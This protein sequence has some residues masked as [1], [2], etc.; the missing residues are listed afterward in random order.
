M[1]GFRYGLCSN[2]KARTE[3]QRLLFS[4]SSDCQQGSQ[5][6]Q[7]YSY[8]NNLT[9][10]PSFGITSSSFNFWVQSLI[11]DCWP[12]GK[13]WMVTLN[14]TLRFL[15]NAETTIRS[16][17]KGTVILCSLHNFSCRVLPTHHHRSDNLSFFFFLF[18]NTYISILGTENSILTQDLFS[19]S[20][21]FVKQD[22]HLPI[23]FIS[24]C[25]MTLN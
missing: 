22:V 16:I 2:Y 18:H 10:I 14:C 24:P 21:Y 9:A 19:V 3:S 11:E 12:C 6:T 13:W 1:Q 25:S 23:N 4:T 5:A 8:V 7:S 20:V 15:H 17:C